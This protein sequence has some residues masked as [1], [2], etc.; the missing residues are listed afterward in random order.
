M[1]YIVTIIAAY[2]YRLILSLD[3]AEISSRRADSLNEIENFSER[4]NA[5]R[6]NLLEWF[7]NYINSQ[8][9]LC[10]ELF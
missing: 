1:P 3:F 6:I 9:L 8:R 4:L 5:A 2:I 10:P 7:I